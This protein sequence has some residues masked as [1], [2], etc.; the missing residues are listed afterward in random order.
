MT[1]DP[2]DLSGDKLS[3]NQKAIT[4][5]E[6]QEEQQRLRWK[7]YVLRGSAAFIA[8][9]FLSALAVIWKLVFRERIY[10]LEIEHGVLVALLL[11]VPSLL[12]IQVFKLVDKNASP[13]PVDL[14]SHPAIKLIREL[15]DKF[16]KAFGR[17]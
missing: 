2:K 8:V 14:E 6:L 16:V 13:K 5:L 10:P 17:H 11:A 3:G 12:A 7:A 1:D 15:V 9:F 4:D